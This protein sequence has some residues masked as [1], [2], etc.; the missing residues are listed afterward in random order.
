MGA[1]LNDLSQLYGRFRET[2]RVPAKEFL[3]NL[4]PDFVNPPFGPVCPFFEMPN[5]R[6]K[7]FYPLFGGSKLRR[8]VVRRSVV[9]LHRLA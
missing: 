1:I 3:L 8:Y 2:N 5:L 9:C 6:F 4:N 7:L